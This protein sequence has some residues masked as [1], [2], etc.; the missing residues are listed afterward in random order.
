MIAYNTEVA[1]RLI[2]SFERENFERRLRTKVLVVGCGTLGSKIAM[3]LA[4]FGYN[5]VLLDP[6]YVMPHNLP[7]Q[8]YC[9][10]DVKKAKVE[11]LAKHIASLAIFPT[12]VRT[13][14][15]R[16]H[17]AVDRKVIPS[18]D[19][20]VAVPDNDLARLEVAHHFYAAGKPVVFAG[21]SQDGLYGY[22]FVQEPGQACFQCAFPNVE[23]RLGVREGC[24]GYAGEMAYV[25]TGFVVFAVDSLVIKHPSRARSWNICKVYLSSMPDLRTRVEKRKECPL[26]SRL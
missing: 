25:L 24:G 8:E 6:D 4:R 16:F 11:A 3:A 5:L 14:T 2:I 17:E 20:A 18:C 12:R 1:E 22:V 7:L 10:A 9:L 19:L 15:M 23:V 13:L 26:C 21:L